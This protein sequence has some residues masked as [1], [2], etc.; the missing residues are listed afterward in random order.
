MSA[1]KVIEMVGTSRN[2]W[3]DAAN[4]AVLEASKSLEGML[5]VEA[6]NFTATIENGRIA[7]YKVDVKIVYCVK[8]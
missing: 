3:T 7:E 6:S 5:G 8:P 1:I 2:N 4:N